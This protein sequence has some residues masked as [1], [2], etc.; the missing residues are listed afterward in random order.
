MQT[1]FL[2]DSS[3]AT[4][5]EI[6]QKAKTFDVENFSNF[7]CLANRLDMKCGCIYQKSK[8]RKGLTETISINKENFKNQMKFIKFPQENHSKI[9]SKQKFILKSPF[10]KSRKSFKMIFC[11][12][13]HQLPTSIPS[14][15]PTKC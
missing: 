12:T 3:V 14:S 2:F 11:K 6:F 7:I 15:T 4:E 9:S 8:S 10:R 5:V 1:I 13:N